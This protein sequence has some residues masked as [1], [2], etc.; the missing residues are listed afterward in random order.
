MN[1]WTIPLT[2]FAAIAFFLA[3]PLILV[4][5][6]LLPGR[7]DVGHGIFQPSVIDSQRSAGD[8]HSV[9]PGRLPD[10]HHFA[11]RFFR[12]PPSCLLPYFR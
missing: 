11:R 12:S 4:L 10:C 6:A 2:I 1:R 3:M 5:M 7:Q 9:A 8:A